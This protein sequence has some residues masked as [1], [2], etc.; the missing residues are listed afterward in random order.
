M[1]RLA[2]IVP[3]LFLPHQLVDFARQQFDIGADLADIFP[4]CANLC[5]HVLSD[6]ANLRQ[7]NDQAG[8]HSNNGQAHR[9]IEL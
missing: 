6:C 3:G 2:S 7:A 4:D 8:N 1:M 5:A 9:D